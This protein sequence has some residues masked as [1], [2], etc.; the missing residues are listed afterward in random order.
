MGGVW[1]GRG[2]HVGGV[3][4]EEYT[5]HKGG[6]VNWEILKI[7]IN[8]LVCIKCYFST[9]QIKVFNMRLPTGAGYGQA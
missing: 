4:W 8:D 6:G 3:G 1:D 2:E 7:G 5:L 9:I